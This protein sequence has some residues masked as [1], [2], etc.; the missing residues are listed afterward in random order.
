M[1]SLSESL[2]T[3]ASQ[4]DR[5]LGG[6]IGSVATTSSM[7]L[8]GGLLQ[9][10]AS[11]P[12]RDGASLLS[13]IS[14]AGSAIGGSSLSGLLAAGDGQSFASQMQALLP[15]ASALTSSIDGVV[16]GPLGLLMRGLVSLFR[17]QQE[18]AAF[19]LYESPDA[20][21]LDLDVARQFTRDESPAAQ[22]PQPGTTGRQQE[23]TPGAGASPQVLIQVNTMDARS[24]ADHRDD[25]ASAV[26][27]ALTRSHSLRD[28]IW[29]D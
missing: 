6:G 29:E 8:A 21:S 16:G 18:P 14:S 17:S 27:E 25:I 13:S 7:G 24:F 10:T 19:S 5:L 12:D 3:V 15:G 4:F 20:L 26:R 11:A 2:R 22:D 1:E 9:G 23:S 28:E